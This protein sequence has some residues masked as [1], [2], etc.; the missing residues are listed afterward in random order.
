MFMSFQNHGIIIHM[1]VNYV[2]IVHKNE[3]NVHAQIFFLGNDSPALKSSILV[4]WLIG[5]AV[6]FKEDNLGEGAMNITKL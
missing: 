6:S 3:W 2:C 5:F 1:H 4:S